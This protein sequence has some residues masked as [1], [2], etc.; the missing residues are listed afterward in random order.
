MAITNILLSLVD[1]PEELAL[2]AIETCVAVAGALGAKVEASAIEEDSSVRP[3]V[4]LSSAVASTALR[5]VSDARGLPETNG[6][7]LLLMGAYRDSRLNQ[8]TWRGAT[9]TVISGLPCWVM[10]S[11]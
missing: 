1:Q 4:G 6:I 5:G 8:M 11:H 10:M 3:Q 7:D 2:G 9:K